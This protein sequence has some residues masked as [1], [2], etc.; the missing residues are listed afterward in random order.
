MKIFD[1]NCGVTIRM[2]PAPCTCGMPNGTHR[3]RHVECHLC[4]EIV[5]MAR[6]TSPPFV[7]PCRTCLLFIERDDPAAN[8]LPDSGGAQERA[9]DELEEA[10]A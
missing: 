3:M 8:E 9:P 5:G 10:P 1:V 7:D 4:G 6:A 2:T